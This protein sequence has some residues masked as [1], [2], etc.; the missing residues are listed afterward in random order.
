MQIIDK[1]VV[2]LIPYDKNP[3]KNEEAV[4][5]V[6]ESIREFGFKVPIIIDKD[7]VIVAGHT[8]LLGAKELGLETVP[9]IVADD[10]T[11]E[12]IKAFRLADNKVS[13][14]AKWDIELLNEE[15]SGILDTDMSIFGFEEIADVDISDF[16]TDT[17]PQEPKV[18]EPQEVQ[19]PH[20]KMFFKL[21]D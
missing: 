2:D 17:E 19:C 14:F 20:C 21:E 6:K 5:Y 16:F 15:L 8:R 9:C 1:K 13:E 7:N 10:L 4:Q 3:R 18:E 11:E 12:Q